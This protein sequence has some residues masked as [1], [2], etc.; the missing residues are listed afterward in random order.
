MP[1]CRKILAKIAD[2]EVM[3]VGCFVSLPKKSYIVLLFSLTVK[4]L[5]RYRYA[6]NILKYNCS[7]T[8]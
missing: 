3:V 8:S 2:R 7:R 1:Q 5:T 4:I 6:G